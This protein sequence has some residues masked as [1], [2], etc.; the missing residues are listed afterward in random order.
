M[1]PVRKS[2]QSPTKRSPK[3]VQK[4]EP[5]ELDIIT[6]PVLYQ[7]GI[8][9]DLYH[10]IMIKTL[11]H[12]LSKNMDWHKMSQEILADEEASG[13]VMD[14][15]TKSP[16]KG[17][18]KGKGRGKAEDVDPEKKGKELTG[19]EL[20]DHF[21][22][23]IFPGLKSGVPIWLGVVETTTPTDDATTPSG[24][25]STPTDDATTP[26]GETSTPTDEAKDSP[27]MDTVE[28]TP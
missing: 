25:T 19:T 23:T 12:A 14:K 24:E 28:F 11:E 10:R 3:K 27:M 20:H 22:N 8:T 2:P 5:L 15:L 26:S 9:N 18:A 4:P 7:S 1:P 6:P 16:K 17:R 21:H 13:I